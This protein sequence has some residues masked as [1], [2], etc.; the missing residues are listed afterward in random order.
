MPLQQNIGDTQL[1]KLGSPL[2]DNSNTASS[3]LGFA[4]KALSEYN[5]DQAAKGL[6]GAKTELRR[7]LFNID[8]QSQNGGFS[9]TNSDPEK[10]AVMAEA[11][12]ATKR[13]SQL[14]RQRGNKAAADIQ[15]RKLLFTMQEKYPQYADELNKQ[16]SQ[17]IS[18]GGS[19]LIRAIESDQKAQAAETL[20]AL[21]QNNKQIAD[22]FGVPYAQIAGMS[23]TQ[24]ASQM[25]GLYAAYTNQVNSQRLLEVAQT[26]A[27]LDTL[28]KQKLQ[29]Q[30]YV[31]ISAGNTSQTIAEI[32]KV[33]QSDASKEDK[34]LQ[35][36]VIENNY[37][38]SMRN[39]F[40]EMPSQVTEAI[41]GMNSIISA[42]NQ[43]A[44]G[45]QKS[46]DLKDFMTYTQSVA[47][48]QQLRRI[49]YD[50][51][52][53]EIGIMQSE[54]DRL[55][56][57]LKLGANLVSQ[58]DRQEIMA[59]MGV[60]NAQ[61]RDKQSALTQA[62][63]SPDDFL[64][65]SQNVLGK[66]LR[67]ELIGMMAQSLTLP[68]PSPVVPA[69][70]TAALESDKVPSNDK[71]A[72]L[73]SASTYLEDPASADYFSKHLEAAPTFQRELRNEFNHE[74][75]S[76]TKEFKAQRLVDSS[77]PKDPRT[78]MVHLAS[79]YAT[80]QVD[81]DALESGQIRFVALKDFSRENQVKLEQ[82]NKT[83]APRLSGT[84]RRYTHANG[85]TNYLAGYR[86]MM[87]LEEGSLPGVTPSE[88][89]SSTRVPEEE[90]VQRVEGYSHL[91]NK[92]G[93]K[94]GVPPELL[95][96]VMYQESRGKEQAVSPAGA[97]GLMQIMPSTARDP[98]LGMPRNND[99]STPDGQVRFAAQF[100]SKLLKEYD[101]NVELALAAYNAGHGA[102]NKAG[103]IPN[104]SE[105]RNYVPAVLGWTEMFRGKDE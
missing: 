71:A 100:L 5:K 6:A 65:N 72:I 15:R 27:N 1:S 11:T 42:A 20:K 85:S 62:L 9:G 80:V 25:S 95:K 96:G 76:F 18:S 26:D 46:Q 8:T 82:M 47:N 77:A 59:Q 22:Q 70:L 102:V 68:E 54:F 51:A 13:I 103:G 14:E 23:P 66:M 49:P 37:R 48:I 105:T 12:A 24:A 10:S 56:N 93:K 33:L 74:L 45:S 16:F 50:Q 73:K 57:S 78:G 88:R 101:G 38:S 98:G 36:S 79:P 69:L 32:Q 84:L 92:Y 86:S 104:N 64:A 34:A 52:N 99:V 63:R 53:S 60:L 17:S 83:I 2:D 31:Q 7:E 39:T 87:N 89:P 4:T 44:S 81:L 75:A 29:E 19:S 61:L 55:Q 35:L 41:S 40:S 94:Y 91:V 30:H 90:A 3:I 21:E 28:S 43:V 67:P 97:Q 58:A